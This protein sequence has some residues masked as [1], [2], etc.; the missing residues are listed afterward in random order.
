MERD[1]TMSL[2][3][4]DIA[5]DLLLALLEHPQEVAHEMRVISAIHYFQ[6]RRLSLGQAAHLAGMPRLEFLDVLNTHGVPAFDLY[7][8]DARAKIAA[9]R[10]QVSH[11]DD[12]E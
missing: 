4:F 12:G 8:D 7:A 6:S 5:D 1:K 3:S 2:I 9:A 10:R 11:R